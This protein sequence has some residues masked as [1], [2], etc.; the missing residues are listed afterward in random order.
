MDDD[1]LN[2]TVSFYKG[3]PIECFCVLRIAIKAKNDLEA[4]H[5]RHKCALDSPKHDFTTIC[6][7]KYLEK[8]P[9][10]ENETI[11]QNLHDVIFKVKLWHTERNLVDGSTDQAQFT[12]LLEETSELHKNLVQGECI[13]D[14]IGDIMVV[15]I[16]I[17]MR[18]DI[19]LSECLTHAYND[20]KDRKGKMVDGL[21][22]KENS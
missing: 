16:N 8:L 4:N 11:M 9:Y 13:K 10:W 20:I 19:T 15:L 1:K 18:N 6:Q 22:I 17:C 2:Y 7:T 12:K 3:T 21:F 14:D 5:I